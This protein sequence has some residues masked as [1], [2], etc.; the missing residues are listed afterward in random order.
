MEQYKYITSQI[1]L[2]YNKIKNELDKNSVKPLRTLLQ[3]FKIRI[4]YQTYW[5]LKELVLDKI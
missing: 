1:T 4:Y 5:E 3:R 2:K